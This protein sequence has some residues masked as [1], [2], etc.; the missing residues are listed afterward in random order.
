MSISPVAAQRDEVQ[1]DLWTRTAAVAGRLNRAHADLV[2]L[3][4]ELIEGGHWGD[5]G[6]KSPEHYFVVRAGLSPAHARDVVAVARRRAELPVLAESVAAG[7]LSLDQ[8]AV[9][10]HHVPASHQRSVGEL[11]PHMTVPQLRRAVSRH[12]FTVES[13]EGADTAESGAAG[14]AASEG[15]PA[16]QSSALGAEQSASERRACATPYLSMHYDRDGR[17]QL[18]YSA[19]APV[20]ALVEQPSR[21][22]R[23]PCSLPRRVQGRTRGAELPVQRAARPP[24]AQRLRAARRH[25]AT[26][27]PPAVPEAWP[28][29]VTV[30]PTPTPWPRSPT[31]PCRP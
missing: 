16:D 14:D 21:K 29:P 7:Q 27:Q 10:A 24:A 5:G 12:A 18:R 6:F 25:P 17:F 9:V 19:P 8:A 30:R 2:D 13:G 26:R 31:G 20:G 15:A 4:V 3:A 22:P 1:R 28:A 23:T 11:A